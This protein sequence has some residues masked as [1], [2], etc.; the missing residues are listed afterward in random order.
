MKLSK[1]ALLSIFFSILIF[2]SGIAIGW[3][4]GYKGYIPFSRV[5]QNTTGITDY[6]RAYNLIR[7]NY[8]GEI[9]QQISTQSS[10]KALISSLN[11]P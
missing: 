9:D 4:Y 5:T 11:D 6:I 7:V 1:K 2:L 8:D 10:I 3:N